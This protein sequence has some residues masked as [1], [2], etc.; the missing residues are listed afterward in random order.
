MRTKGLVVVC[1]G[2]LSCSKFVSTENLW[3]FHPYNKSIDSATVTNVHVVW[4]NHFDAGFD[5]K[6]WFYQPPQGDSPLAYRV[7]QNYFDSY[8]PLAL[9]MASNA[10][11]NNETFSW[12]TQ[13]W[14]ISLFFDCDNAAVYGWDL[15]GW[16]STQVPLLKCPNET[17][18]NAVKKGIMN[19]DI[20]FHAFPHNALLGLYD[21]SL[22]NASLLQVQ[23]TAKSFG[24]PLP[25]T[26]SQRD[27]PGL[28]RASL[29]LLNAYGVEFVSVGSGGPKQGHPDIPDIFVWKDSATNASVL[30]THDDGYGG[31]THV[32]SNGHALYCA[33]NRDNS[34]PLTNYQNILTRLRTTYPNAKVFTST[35][36][37]FLDEVKPVMSNLPVVTSEIGDTWAYGAA[38]DPLKLQV[39]REISRERVACLNSGVCDI[40]DVSF[41]RFDRLLLKIPEHT[42]GEDIQCYYGDNLNWTN[43]Q[44]LSALQ[45]TNSDG[46]Y[47]LP[48]YNV[49][50]D[51]W[52]EQR[53]Y[54][55]NAI[56]VLKQDM[57]YKDFA[58][59]LEDIITRFRTPKPTLQDQVNN[60]HK[61]NDTDIKWELFDNNTLTC[62]LDDGTQAVVELDEHGGIKKYTIANNV[63]WEEGSMG[64]F[65]Y[66]T[67][68]VDDY[69]K[70]G[71]KYGNFKYCDVPP[72][73][74]PSTCQ[75]R[76]QYC[77]ASS[78][79]KVNFSHAN[80]I[81]RDVFATMKSVYKATDGSC[82]Y[83]VESILP[84]DVHR[85][86]GSPSKVFS[87][88]TIPK[89]QESQ[90]TLQ[91]YWANKTVT[92]LAEA[93]WVQFFPSLNATT[94]QD[95]KFT[96]ELE[97]LGSFV[98]ALD[99]V[100]RGAVNFFPADA[101]RVNKTGEQKDKTDGAITS[102]TVAS[103]DAPIL[104]VGPSWPFP[105]RDSE[106]VEGAPNSA[107]NLYNNIWGTNYVFWYPY[108]GKP[109]D[110]FDGEMAT[111]RFDI[112][113][114]F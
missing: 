67:V 34:G 55:T 29:R 69:N 40:Q 105:T 90:V 91:L 58:E 68:G 49:T 96:L 45:Y 10:S 74:Q 93:L 64:R 19:G 26:L 98:D 102:I 35:F 15:S 77:G 86:A 12:M 109:G 89:D 87:H 9:E 73:T 51:S 60:N 5:D 27:V 106:Q 38:S 112:R 110:F 66:Q 48:N 59:T 61:K 7:I 46:A 62:D 94:T 2:L 103:L 84:E 53:S 83:M 80:P 20:Y 36:D 22:F 8:F 104:G 6:S 32:A 30:F 13:Q 41:M 44:L 50:L 33:W 100:N 57:K 85:D 47:T 75:E 18:I 99:V 54:L 25:R 16:T 113:I 17:M 88:I 71:A 107:F 42:W 72:E 23:Q 101:I 92:K 39:F 63:V 81:R 56:L 108:A 3:N 95:N 21:E 111:F 11:A 31:G 70:Y 114:T 65:M 24:I 97:K 78:F 43:T 14:L 82:S 52:L 79:L 37:Q 76:V 1:L 28:T 4:S